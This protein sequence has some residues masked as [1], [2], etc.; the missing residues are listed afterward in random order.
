MLIY[1]NLAAAKVSLLAPQVNMSR[2]I[3]Q[4]LRAFE[5]VRIALPI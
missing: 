4:A 3:V 2:R 5:Q 1:H